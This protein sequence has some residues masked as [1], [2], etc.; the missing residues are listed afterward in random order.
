GV[1]RTQDLMVYAS[2]SSVGAVELARS[3]GTDRR[4]VR[5]APG[6]RIDLMSFSADGRTLVTGLGGVH[7]RVLLVDVAS[8]RGRGVGGGAPA[9][10]GGVARVV[11]GR[12]PLSLG[13]HRNGGFPPP[14]V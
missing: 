4:A 10:G 7:G 13:R 11:R 8:R 5:I 3:E 12:G 1:A 9:Q 14:A 6:H 2:S